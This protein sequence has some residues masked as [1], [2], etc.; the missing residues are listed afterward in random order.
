MG[1]WQG[2]RW[3]KVTEGMMA[4][5]LIFLAAPPLAFKGASLLCPYPP[6]L[7]LPVQAKVCC[8][9]NHA[10]VQYLINSLQQT[11]RIAAAFFNAFLFYSWG[12]YHAQ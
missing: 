12:C 4:G 3:G 7:V 11:I 9:M 2:Y 1:L 5:G 8:A 10:Y 6:W